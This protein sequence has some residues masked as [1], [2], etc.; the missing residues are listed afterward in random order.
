EA[1]QNLRSDLA[2][3]SD[4]TLD[5]FALRVKG[6]KPIPASRLERDGL[7]TVF[8]EASQVEANTNQCGNQGQ[9]PS[10]SATPTGTAS[11]NPTVTPTSLPTGNGVPTPLPTQTATGAP[12]STST[13]GPTAEPTVG[14]TDVPTTAPTIA[15]TTA[16]TE[17]MTPQP[18]PTCSGIFGIG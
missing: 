18:T 1:L 7:Y 12:T 5:Q 6:V 4:V 17:V 10:P 13:A 9:V 16:P 11:A 8:Y 14:P 3:A 2:E 15:P